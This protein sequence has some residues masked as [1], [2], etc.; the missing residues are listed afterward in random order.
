MVL[1]NRLSIRAERQAAEER[2]W[3]VGILIYIHAAW[4]TAPLLPML[5]YSLL[6]H[7]TALS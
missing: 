6:R 5:A 2:R 3:A 4:K 1:E 7:G